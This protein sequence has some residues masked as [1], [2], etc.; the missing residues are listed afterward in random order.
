MV[1]MGHIPRN[2]AT[3]L[4]P[5]KSKRKKGRALSIEEYRTLLAY[6]PE[7]H[8][9]LIETLARTG[10]RFSEATAL[11]ARRVELNRDIPLVNVEEAWKRT[12]R[13]GVYERGGPRAWT[14][15]ASFRSFPSWPRSCRAAAHLRAPDGQGAARTGRSHGTILR[16]PTG[17]FP[18][19]YARSSLTRG[20]GADA[21]RART[22]DVRVTQSPTV[23]SSIV[24]RPSICSTLFARCA[25]S[26]KRGS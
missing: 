26:V 8:Q 12:E 6:I 22:V 18:S 16:G 10:M 9:P 13:C 14:A 24:S 3:G 7:H 23:E 2:L 15:T 4:G 25:R 20:I 17:V 19:V 1:K 21:R 5:G 11:M